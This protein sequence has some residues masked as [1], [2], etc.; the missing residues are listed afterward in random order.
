FRQLLGCIAVQIHKPS[1][2]EYLPRL[3]ERYLKTKLVGTLLGFANSPD[4][5][6]QLKLSESIYVNGRACL[7][8]FLVIERLLSNKAC[9]ERLA[10]FHPSP[11][12]GDLAFGNIIVRDRSCILIDPNARSLFPSRGLDYAKTLQSLQVGYE[13]LAGMHSAHR[14]GPH[15]H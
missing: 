12:H 5:P 14:D 6:T 3:S 7:A 10:Q 1:R 8:P 9:L 11:V 13:G 15:I 2:P 4:W